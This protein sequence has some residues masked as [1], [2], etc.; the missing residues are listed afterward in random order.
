MPPT[1]PPPP[2]AGSTV[3][4][5]EEFHLV[6]PGSLA[7]TPSATVAAAALAGRAG[8]HV[9]P[10]IVTT[11]LETSTGVC[12][13]I[14][15]LRAQ[16]A[17]TRA[18]AA[19][20]AA[21]DGL[22]LFAA[23]THPFGTWREQRIT[24]APRYEAMVGRWAG[25]A[26]RQDICGCHVHV[27]VPDVG[28]AVAV[29]DRA[30]PYLPV[31]LAMTGSSPF[32]DGADT[33]HESWR[34][35]WWS[36]WPNA[37]PPEPM[38]TEQRFRE[39]LDG[40]VRSGVVEDGRHLYWDVR[41]SVRWP[42]LEFRLADVCT[43]LDAAVLHAALVRSLVR[44]LA[45]RAERGEPVPEVR[46]ELLRAARWRAARDGLRGELFDPVRGEVAAAR[47]AVEALVAELADDL[48]THGEE[49]D[50]AAL[51]DRLWA[52]GTSATR[53]RAAWA[54]TRDLRAVAA[55]VVRDGAAGIG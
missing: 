30:R 47:D 34:T 36:H 35:V 32:H 41:P 16:L 54:A 3:G 20:A 7:L 1:H 25:L 55:G 27:G 23:S 40:L 33:G 18:E 10:E 4:V 2:P 9:H 17:A 29:M 52:H 24:G 13:G 26:Q 6:D 22:V 51:L 49:D 21:R 19:A 50:V 15:E 42:T 39:V 28:T 53:Q 38:G 37:G 31:L 48:R 43:D 45:R 12:T 46:P 14:G 5:E 11:Q 44:V 8:E